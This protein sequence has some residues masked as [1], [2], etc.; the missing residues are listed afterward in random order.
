MVILCNIRRILGRNFF[1]KD[2][3][4]KK[5]E[6]ILPIYNYFLANNSSTIKS[7]ECKLLFLPNNKFS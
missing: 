3:Q 6:I 2:L 5:E 4:I 7:F 1:D